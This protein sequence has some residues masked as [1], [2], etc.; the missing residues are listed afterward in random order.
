MIV[1]EDLTKVYR[2]SKRKQKELNT[3][4]SIK[5]AVNSVSLVAK[6]G[7]IYGLLGPNGAGKTTA[8]RCI[9]TLL[10]PTDGTITVC[11]HDT[12][13]DS[14]IVRGKISFLTNEIKLDP[15]F[16]PRYMFDF[17]AKLYNSPIK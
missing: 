14:E 6:P 8:L 1:I 16:S 2:L 4:D 5:K 15:Q 17:F 7:E 3:Q 9:A 10:K 13:K 12:I 11:G